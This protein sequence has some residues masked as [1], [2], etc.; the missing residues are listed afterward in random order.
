MK[1]KTSPKLLNSKIQICLLVGYLKIWKHQV[2]QAW[3]D[4][5]GNGVERNKVWFCC[6]VTS[7]HHM[8]NSPKKLSVYM[9]APALPCP[10]HRSLFQVEPLPQVKCSYIRKC[11]TSSSSWVLQQFVVFGTHWS[12]RWI[13]CGG[14]HCWETDY[15]FIF[16]LL[17]II[18]DFQHF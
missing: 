9:T 18:T 10:D 15:T 8:V 16:C 2:P 4:R 5:P 17:A 1:K 12:E 6:I 7:H 11:P 14:K 3:I 13:S